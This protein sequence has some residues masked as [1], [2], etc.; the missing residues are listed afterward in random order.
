MAKTQT[1]NNPLQEKMQQLVLEPQQPL[2][3]PKAAP[4][5]ITPPA[6]SV[7]PPS[8]PVNQQIELTPVQKFQ[9]NLESYEKAILPSLLKAHN[10]EPAQFKYIVLSEVKKNP[11]LLECFIQNP[12]SLF[13]SILAGA[14]IGLMPSE[15]LGEFFLIPRRID[16]RMT[17]TPQIGYKGMVSI[18]TRS[19]DVVKVDTKCVYEGDQ[20]DVWYGFEDK[21]VHKPNF[22]AVRNSKTLRNVYAVAKLKSGDYQYTVMTKA[23]IMAVAAMS[24]YENDL[25]LNDKKDP[26]MWMV[27]KVALM[28]LAKLL[29]KDYYGKKALELENRIEGGGVLMLDEDNQVTVVDGKKIVATRYSSVKNTL[30]QLPD[31]PTE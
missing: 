9:G 26:N 1:T 16:N 14:E 27:R 31:I 4:S 2:A 6:P 29:P 23:E 3:Q 10:I 28:Q 24:K 17:A 20:F 18:L 19:G 13:A 25:Y 7:Q 8:A 12:A 5:T 11:K 15:L 22:D 21:I 30:N